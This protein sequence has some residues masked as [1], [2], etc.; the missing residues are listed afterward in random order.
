[1]GKGVEFEQLRA[2]NKR[3]GDAAID[4]TIWPELLDLISK[5]VGAAGAGLLQSDIRTADIPR[6]PGA[7][8]VISSYFTNGWHTRD[9]RAERGVPLL[10][11]GQKV[12]TDQDIVTPQEMQRLGFYTEN[13]APF[14]FQWFAAIGFRSGS[15]LWALAIQR[16]TREGPFGN[17]E[18][19]ALAQFSQR[20][21]EIATL[22]RAVG[23]AVLTG[24]TNALYRIQQ[25][26]LALDRLGFVIDISPVAEQL[27]DDE[28]RVTDNRLFVRDLLAQRDI[29]DLIDK[30]RASS[31]TAP[32]SAVP[33]VV[34]RRDRSPIIIH[35][36][37]V[38]GAARSPF[39]GAR[40]L[41]ILRDMGRICVPEGDLL[42]RTFDLSPAEIR[43][44]TRVGVGVSLEA[45][46]DQLGIARETARTQLKAIF[47]KTGTHRQPELVA[48]L[49]RL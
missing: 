24:V 45:A 8:E 13:L 19:R 17:E 30:L 5:A 3:L 35:I 10:L 21:T 14:G 25:P 15:A 31:D 20:L 26:V 47:A 28:I 40:A 1:M 2:I 6:S 36:L 37:P 41:L 18:K 12:V 49:S 11:R 4:P 48:L 34:R 16:T 39:L 43:L 27:F 33:I 29:N 23:R 7:D 9:V 38:D 22:S 42:R 44:A 32:L 46:A